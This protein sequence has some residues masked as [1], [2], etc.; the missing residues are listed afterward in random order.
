MCV[1]VCVQFYCKVNRTDQNNHSNGGER[2]RT[3]CEILHWI[4]GY[5]CVCMCVCDNGIS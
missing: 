1:C 3:A 4:A 2:E 5:L